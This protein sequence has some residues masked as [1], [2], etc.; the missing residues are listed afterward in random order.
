M[1]IIE[2]CKNKAGGYCN[3]EEKETGAQSR[4][5]YLRS[6]GTKRSISEVSSESTGEDSADHVDARDEKTILFLSERYDSHE[7]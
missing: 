1:I 6:A 3:G 2:S 4:R 7:F 5:D